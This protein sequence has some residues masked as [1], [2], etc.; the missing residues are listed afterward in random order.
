[1]LKRLQVVFLL[2]IATVGF[3]QD[4]VLHR[5]IFIGDAGEIN[6]KQETIVSLAADLI[7]PEKTTVLY[8]GDNIYPRGL[9]LPGSPDRLETEAI[10]KSQFIPLRAKGAPVYFVPGNHDW[11]RMGELG[12]EKIRAQGEFLASQQDSLLKL[13]PANGCPDPVE[14]PLSSNAVM[15]AYDSEWWL[16]PYDK[17]N[18]N[19][20]CECNTKE[21]VLEKFEELFYKNRDKTI[22][23]A[24]HHPFKSFGVHG[25][26]YSLKDHLFPFTVLKKNLYIPL[27]VIGSLYPLLRT[28]V[29]LNPEDMP[30]P[31]YKDLIEQVS[32]VFK[33]YPNL[34]YVAGHEH[35]LQL[36]KTGDQHQVV[37]GSGAKSSYLKSH[38]DLLY[39]QSNQGFVLVD[40]M[41]DKSTKLT[42]YTYENQSVKVSFE[43]IIPFVEETPEFAELIKDGADSLVIQANP[44]YDQ[45]GKRHRKLFGENYRKEWAAPTK[46]P[47]LRVSE[48]AGGLKPIQRGGGCKLF[49]CV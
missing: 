33:G 39:K 35:G 30:H 11:D 15:I 28:T 38:K 12:L 19:E 37:S 14:I 31:L 23:L 22:L 41:Q 10:L 5:V 20:S 1:M 40:L 24:S 18:P 25:G 4:K 17:G 48:I 7:L 8:L 36:I 29:F 46:V 13:V 47:A 44:K 27:P 2:F 45:V 16:F 49:L 26:Y 42:Y 21:E 3:A 34:I 32:G 43:Y 9:G 6:F